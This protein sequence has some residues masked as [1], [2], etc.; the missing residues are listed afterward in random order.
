MKPPGK[1]L[2]YHRRRNVAKDRSLG[3]RIVF[4]LNWILWL[5]FLLVLVIILTPL[6]GHMLKPL[7]VREDIRKADFIVVLSGGINRGRYLSLVSSQ[8]M[9]RGAQLYFEGRA[10]KM[11]FTGGTPEKIGVAEAA[12][13]A[14]E[15]KRLNVPAEDILLETRSKN[16]YEQVGEIKK[17][18]GPLHWKSLLLVTSYSNMKRSLM[19]FEYAG[20]KVYPAPADPYEKYVDDPLGR[21]SLFKQLIHEYR[22]ILYYKIRGRI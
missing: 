14:Q 2:P 12:V 20:F 8:R 16:P 3:G 4:I 22:G 15:A 11:L 21:L 1:W 13:M 18:A 10:K 7:R 17:I 9:V 19:I 6:T 5:A